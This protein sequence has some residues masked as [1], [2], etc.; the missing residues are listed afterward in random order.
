[1]CKKL[2]V[3]TMLISSIILSACGNAVSPAPTDLPPTQVSTT[4][5]V[6]PT[7]AVV[8]SAAAPTA[9]VILPT[10]NPTEAA[11]PT[12]LP[13]AAGLP[14]ITSPQVYLDDR[15]TPAALMLSYFNAINRQ[16]YL[17]A[18]SYYANVT[19]IGT[20]DQFSRG[21]SDTK[22]VGVVFGPISGEGAAGSVYYTVPMVLNSSKTSG[23]QEKFAACYILR[24]PQPANYG[25][26]PI[27]PL[28]I[29]KSTAQ[30]VTLATTDADALAEACPS[31][32]FAGGPNT[33]PAAVEQIS[34]LSSANFIDNRSDPAAVISS[35]L[36]AINRR[37]YVRAYSYWQTTSNNYSAFAAGYANTATVTAQFGTATS[38]PG[39]GQIY[40]SLPV[41]MKATLTDGT[42]QTFVGCY[43]LHISQPSFQATPP[44]KPLGITDGSFKQV[45]NTADLTS[46]L[47]T[48]CS[49]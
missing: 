4:I 48:A 38:D 25:A 39:A 6:I 20:F 15:S 18:Y 26:P 12:Q 32:D 31:P 27:T 28:H 1:M 22:T 41:A 37:E 30:K 8:P 47:A 5:V 35:L 7:A 44:F 10:T 14:D 19:E 46:M 23:T 17:R 11:T 24:F 43:T 9:P 42:L 29:D 34:D 40:Y 13:P 3:Y 21:Y 16:E 49:Q 36:N 2:F 45:D 33:A